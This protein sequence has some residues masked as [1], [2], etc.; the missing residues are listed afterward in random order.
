ML[1]VLAIANKQHTG[2]AVGI[3]VARR[4]E[5]KRKTVTLM[6]ILHFSVRKEKGEV[7]Y[8]KDRKI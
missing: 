8:S 3:S 2:P 5:G 4:L 6:Y 7:W 1:S